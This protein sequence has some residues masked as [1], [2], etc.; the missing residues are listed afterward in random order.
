MPWPCRTL[1]RN[2]AKSVVV[3]AVRDIPKVRESRVY[4]TLGSGFC[5]FQAFAVLSIFL[6]PLVNDGR[7]D[8]Y[9][10]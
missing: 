4:M 8:Y 7:K 6:H 10:E 1:A 2:Q 5:K 3:R 9:V